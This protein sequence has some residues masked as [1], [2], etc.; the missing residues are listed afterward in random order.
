MSNNKERRN[1]MAFEK[2]H[3]V[4]SLVGGMTTD[5]FDFWCQKCDEQI[6]RLVFHSED[7]VG[8]KLEAKCKK[9]NET[10]IFKVKVTPP[11]RPF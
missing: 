7:S 3:S 11:L 10:M 2:S 5:Y 4:H 9:C 1:I 6:D 8:V